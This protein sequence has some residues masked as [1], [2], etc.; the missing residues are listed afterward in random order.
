MI[1]PAALLDEPRIREF[2]ASHHAVDRL[3]DVLAEEKVRYANHQ[4][5]LLFTFVE[6]SADLPAWVESIAKLPDQEAALVTFEHVRAKAIEIDATAEKF[7]RQLS[8]LIEATATDPRSLGV[9]KERCVKA[10][11]YFTDQIATEL[12]STLHKHLEPLAY[13]KKLKRYVRLVRAMQD[14]CW[15]KIDSLY[16]ARFLDASIFDG[17]RKHVRPMASPVAS[18]TK[19]QGQT[20]R[21]TLDLYRQGRTVDEI[22]TLR[23]LVPSTIKGHLARWIGSREVDV[24]DLLAAETINMV[25]A[26]LEKNESAAL[27]ELRR[28]TGD[29]IDHGDIKM[30]AAYHASLRSR[31]QGS[32]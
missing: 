22:A 19:L 7:R 21:E 24:H 16:A 4:L 29:T 14:G 30:V 11:E 5:L 32:T 20:F 18:A 12:V 15:R 8:R 13:K 2:S 17:K 28:E 31:R 1:T 10:I 25:S 3:R 27:S 26:L 6:L 23:G 9:V